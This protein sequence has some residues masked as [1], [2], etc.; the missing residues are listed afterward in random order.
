MTFPTPPG[1]FQP[2]DSILEYCVS[3]ETPDILTL[4]ELQTT[5]KLH[6]VAAVA[7]IFLKDNDL[8]ERDIKA[9][10]IKSKLLV[11]WGTSYIHLLIHWFAQVLHWSSVILVMFLSHF[12]TLHIL[13]CGSL[14][15]IA[16]S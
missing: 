9:E 13:F 8:L 4:D 16:H 15:R 12:P 14:H 7:M 1:K 5:T 2:P 10:D 11:H 6:R 3:L